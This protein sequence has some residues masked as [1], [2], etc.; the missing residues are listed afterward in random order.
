MTRALLIRGML[1]GLLAGLL[2]FGFGRVFGEPSVDRAIGFEAAAVHGHGHDHGPPS[3]EPESFS[4]ATQ[5]GIGLL[6]GTVVYAAA[7]GG[8]LALVFA[9]AH[10]RVGAA[11]PRAVAATLA[12][13][14]FLSLCLVPMAI[15]PANPP[16]VGEAA[17]IAQRTALF[18]ILIGVSVFGLVGAVMLRGILRRRLDDWSATLAAV[19]CYVLL[20]AGAAALLPAID[21]VPPGF[22]ATTLWRFRLASVG[23]Q[24]VM[25]TT[26]GLGFGWAAER[27]LSPQ[28]PGLMHG[29]RI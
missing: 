5:S 13:C 27:L 25:W 21:E 20:I 26:L 29:V 22:P 10:G 7:F 19:A 12:A 1:V 24:L 23:L 17:T 14:G 2:M 4:R 16:A 15:Y 11:R 28:R 6:T 9:Y 8:L 3:A 18:F